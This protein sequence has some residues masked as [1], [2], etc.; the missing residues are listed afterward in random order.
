[1]SVRIDKAIV[2]PILTGLMTGIASKVFLG[3]GTVN[4][5]IIN[6]PI[7]SGI[8]YGLV[9]YAASSLNSATKYVTLPLLGVQD[10]LAYSAQMI[11]SPLLTGSSLVAVQA[12]INLL[13]GS[14][15]I[16]SAYAALE[17]VAIGAGSE[18]SAD[19]AIN[20]FLPNRI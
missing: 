3:S 8:G 2:K 1:M 12:G 7:D 6:Y 17:S 15:A 16:P 20:T 9:G 18:I 19:Y 4:I 5:P 11:V 10:P 13:N 14:P